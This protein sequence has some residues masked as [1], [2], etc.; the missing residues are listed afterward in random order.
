MM[1]SIIVSQDIAFSKKSPTKTAPQS[2]QIMN[3]SYG[4]QYGLLASLKKYKNLMW[5]ACRNVMP[6]KENLVRRTII[7]D[8]TCDRCH[9]AP[10]SRLPALW[11]CRELDTVWMNMEL[12]Q[13]QSS[14]SFRGLKELLSWSFQQDNNLELFAVTAWLIWSQRNKT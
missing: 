11:S 8:Q 1:A 13:I 7:S 4:G 12:W 9:A 5:C 14:L 10:K 3:R 2:R 6:T